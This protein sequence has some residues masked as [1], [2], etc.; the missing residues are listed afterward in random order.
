MPYIEPEI[1]CFDVLPPSGQYP[2]VREGDR[3]QTLQLCKVWDA[4]QLL[5]LVP[6]SPGPGQ[7]E[8]HL[9][10]FSG[11]SKVK[12]LTARLETNVVETL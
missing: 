4:N 2:D 5:R 1:K 7:D 9:Q 3:E 6:I 8:P 10:K 11:T 12:K